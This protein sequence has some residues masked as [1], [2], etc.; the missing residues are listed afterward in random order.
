M[1]WRTSISS[2]RPPSSHRKSVS[3][4]GTMCPS[5]SV[6][7]GSSTVF[8]VMNS[9]F[10]GLGSLMCTVPTG[11]RDDPDEADEADEAA[12]GDGAAGD[13]TAP[14]KDP[15]GAGTAC[16]GVV[17]VIGHLPAGAMPHDLGHKRTLL[18]T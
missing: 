12:A 10:S 11:R 15:I 3:T 9:Q 8:Q 18:S 7:T 1:P 14:P 5:A 6:R 2:V 17:A 13:G 16:D 4:A